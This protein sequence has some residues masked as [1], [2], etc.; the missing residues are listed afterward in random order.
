MTRGDAMSHEQARDLLPW[1]VNDSLKADE[2]DRVD[3]HAKSCV[4]CRREL[5]ELGNLRASIAQY[6]DPIAVP[7]PDMRR[8]NARIDA[9]IEKETRLQRLL[10]GLREFMASPWR[11]AF[12]AQTALLL[13]LG[14]AMLWP[15][16]APVDYITLTSPQTL[17][18]GAYIRVVFDPTLG[19]PELSDLLD[20]MHLTLVEGPSDRGVATLGFTAAASVAERHD[21]VANLLTNPAVL[22]A[23]PV[24]SGAQ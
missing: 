13:I 18:D 14:T 6:D 16:D 17:P 19:G 12:A 4:I 8:I 11:I 24:T 22:F 23:V 9:L 1:L 21:V 15:Q 3:E 20:A 7:A 10:S 2:R 5:A